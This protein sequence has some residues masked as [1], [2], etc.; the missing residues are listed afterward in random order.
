MQEL[1]EAQR[2]EGSLSSSIEGIGKMVS[3]MEGDTG[4]LHDDLERMEGI[5]ERQALHV[6][7]SEWLSERVIPAIRS[8]ERSMMALMAE[9]MDG[10]AGHWFGQLVED[11]DLVLS[12]D[13]E[14][15]PTVTHQDYE[16]DLG[17]LSGGERTAAA[18]A[19]RLALNG[20][21]RSNATPDQ[22][23]LLILDEPTDG[24]SREQLARMGNVFTELAADQVV[25]VSH[26]RELRTFAD[27]V[28]LVEKSGGSSS[29]RQVA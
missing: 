13:E 27:R 3:K 16:M 24:F 17:A 9:E 14:F 23:N 10:A 8:M 26:D 18:F 2:A 29:V 11:P 21:V 12:V 15:V 6:H 20:L 5:L 1:Q 4:R 22:R 19:Y 7:V 25:V 28:Y